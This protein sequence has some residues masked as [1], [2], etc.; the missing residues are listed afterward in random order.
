MSASI[1]PSKSPPTL[2][3]TLRWQDAFALAMAVSGGLFVSFGATMAAI[4][5]LSAMFI[6]ALAAGIG[7]AQNHLFAEMASMFPDKPGGVPIYAHEAWKG[8]F[9]PAGALATF[10][11]WFGWSAVISIVSLTAGAIIQVRW[12]PVATW[13]LDL[14]ILQVGPAQLIGIVLILA[15]MVPNLFGAQPAAWVNKIFGALLL[16]PLL[17][18]VVAPLVSGQWDVS[19]LSWGLG[20]AGADHWGGWQDAAVWLY[21]IGW[22]AYGTEMCAAFTPEYRSKKDARR[23]LS[24]S[25]AYTFMMFALVPIGIG[26]LLSQ[27]DAAADPA[28]VFVSGFAAVLPAGFAGDAALLITIG[29]LL[30]GVNASMA[31]GSRALFGAAVDGLVPREFE[32]LNR[33]QVP[34]RAIAAAVV[35]NILLV[36]FVSNPISILVAANIGYLLAILLAVS[37]F[38]LLRWDRPD[39]PRSFKLGRWSI[40]LAIVLTI[41]GAAVLIVGAASSQ[42]SG[43]GGPF[44]LTI[45]V[46]ILLLSLVL[47]VIRRR[48]Q[49][50]LPLMREPQAPSDLHE[51]Q[52]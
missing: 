48:F 21:L 11:Y 50:R 40:P 30:M 38:L 44:E 1:D 42:I 19:N 52:A 8:R 6:W 29:A 18:F 22:T 49:D 34:A 17:T 47:F 9:A 37:G 36:L 13:V 31:D 45:G 5:A 3:R 14:G 20:Q 24:S 27:A 4:G 2:H 41:Y 32:K 10:G 28:A 33:H 25:G 35:M 12:F 23:A 51:T 7:W 26:G 46:G 15:L 43:Y 16:I 39:D